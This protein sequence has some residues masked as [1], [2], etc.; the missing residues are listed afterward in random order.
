MLKCEFGLGSKSVVWCTYIFLSVLIS[1]FVDLEKNVGK[2]LMWESFSYTMYGVYLLDSLK[3]TSHVVL[4][5]WFENKV[6]R[7]DSSKLN[8]MEML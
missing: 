5:R 2:N 4:G 7:S 1:D 6:G 3:G 8:Q